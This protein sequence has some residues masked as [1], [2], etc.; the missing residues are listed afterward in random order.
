MM[1]V[2]S[3]GSHGAGI[4][5]MPW[6]RSDRVNMNRLCVNLHVMMCH[7]D[8]T[9]RADPE[10]RGGNPVI[11]RLEIQRSLGNSASISVH[12]D[13]AQSSLAYMPWCWVESRKI[14]GETE[15]DF[16]RWECPGIILS[17]YRESCC[18]TRAAAP[19]GRTLLVRWTPFRAIQP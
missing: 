9:D 13:L 16:W 17:S 14:P 8:I 1:T 10:V 19:G 4:H 7:R 12:G 5:R 15:V 18:E 11:E 2:R 6:V 3:A